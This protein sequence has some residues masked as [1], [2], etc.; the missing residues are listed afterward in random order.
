MSGFV[1][2][3]DNMLGGFRVPTIVNIELFGS[4]VVLYRQNVGE[5][6]SHSVSIQLASGNLSMNHEPSSV[7]IIV[8]HTYLTPTFWVLALLFVIWVVTRTIESS[9]VEPSAAIVWLINK[10]SGVVHVVYMLLLFFV[11]AGE[12]VSRGTTAHP[13]DGVGPVVV[14]TYSLP[15]PYTFMVMYV[16]PGS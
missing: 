6:H 14:E 4:F 9:G 2:R 1:G 11:V 16:L 13:E 12:H 7:S 8:S 5:S 3:G 10:F 15:V